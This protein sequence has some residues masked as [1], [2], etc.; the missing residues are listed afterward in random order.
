MGHIYIS[1][2]HEN[3]FKS[4]ITI[5][6][7]IKKAYENGPIIIDSKQEMENIYKNYLE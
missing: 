3:L 7:E 1:M 2:K 6:A 5:N 4:S